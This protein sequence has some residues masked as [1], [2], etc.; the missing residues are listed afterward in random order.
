[1]EVRASGALTRPKS[2]LVILRQQGTEVTPTAP[3]FDGPTNK[4]TIPNKTGVQ[5]LVNGVP[6]IAGDITITEDVLVEAEAK[7]DYYIPSS[8][9]TSWSFTHTP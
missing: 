2:A 8:D 5:Y 9:N 3:S 4:L 6:K 1:M 7:P